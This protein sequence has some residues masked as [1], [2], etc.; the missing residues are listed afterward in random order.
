MQQVH[1]KGRPATY[2]TALALL[3][4]HPKYMFNL[5]AVLRSSPSI[6]AVVLSCYVQ[7]VMGEDAIKCMRYKYPADVGGG[8]KD[9]AGTSLRKSEFKSAVEVLIGLRFL[10]SHVEQKWAVMKAQVPTV[11]DSDHPMLALWR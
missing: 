11:S 5:N 7:A 4:R 10:S 6:H 1:K 2:S 9:P 3:C 8:V